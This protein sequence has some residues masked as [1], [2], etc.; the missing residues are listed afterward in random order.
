MK[1]CLLCVSLLAFAAGTLAEDGMGFDLAAAFDED[2]TPKPKEKQQPKADDGTGFDLSDALGPDETNKLDPKQPDVPPKRRGGGGNTFGDS[3]LVDLAGGDANNDGDRHAGGGG[4]DPGYDPRGGAGE[5]PQ[6][7]GSGTIAAIVSA[8]GVAVVGAAS[9]Y[10][11][12]QKKKLCFKLQG[13]ADP[14]SGKGQR[15]PSDPQVMSNLLTK[16]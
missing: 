10:F 9:S 15:G 5:E 8:I 14:E 12:Y 1:F 7:A 13:G 4:R 11:A 3:D 6:E 2:P 16:S